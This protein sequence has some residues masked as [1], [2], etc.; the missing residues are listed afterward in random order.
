MLSVMVAILAFGTGAWASTVL[1]DPNHFYIN[2]A[3]DAGVKYNLD[4]AYY[5]DTYSTAYSTADGGRYVIKFDGGGLNELG[6]SN[7]TN[8]S[9]TKNVTA[10]TSTVSNPTG[11]FY[12]TNTGGRGFDDDLILLVSVKGPLS[13][14]FSINITSSGYTWTPNA[15]GAYTPAITSI[16]PTYTNQALNETFYASDFTYGAQALKPGTS[17]YTLPLYYGETASGLN[18]PANNEYLMFVDLNAGNLS[19]GK[20]WGFTLTDNGA[21]KVD[22]SITGLYSE[23]LVA[24]NGYGWCSASN[25]NEGI[26][27][28]NNTTFGASNAS[29]YTVTTSAVAPVP[30]PPAVYSFA[31]GL[32]G[33]VAIR[34]RK[35]KG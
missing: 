8:T 7:T 18:D 1:T 22:F 5:G 2:V 6:I 31:S 35:I 11:T 27:F 32:I 17:A 28:S 4:Y 13:S 21:L 30:I 10:Q 25:Q 33:L 19:A 34:R 24:F 20:A 29:G 15:A 9:S 14:N 26:S 23:N 12:L 16:T 3:N